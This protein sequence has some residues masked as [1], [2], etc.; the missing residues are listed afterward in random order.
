MRKEADDVGPQAELDYWKK[1]MAKFDSLISSLK[2]PECKTVLNV[3]I[4]AKSKVLE[5]RNSNK[6]SLLL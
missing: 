4:A 2:G 3:L 1:R 5:V 6:D